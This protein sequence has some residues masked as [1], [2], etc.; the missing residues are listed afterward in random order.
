MCLMFSMNKTD[1]SSSVHYILHKA[2]KIIFI[3]Q[4][5]DFPCLFIREKWSCSLEISGNIPE[6]FYAGRISMASFQCEYAS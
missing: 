6:S 4:N 1:D 5:R 3:L 2:C